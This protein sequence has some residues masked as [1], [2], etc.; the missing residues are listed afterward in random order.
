MFTLTIET[1]NAAMQTPADVGRA[2]EKVARQLAED[3]SGYPDG[4]IRDDN[5]NT[6][7]RYALE[8]GAKSGEALLED[9]RQALRDE[10]SG[11]GGVDE[12]EAALEAIAGRL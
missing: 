6:V 8:P 4:L 1:G 7:G 3:L 11:A 9:L 12:T 5:G 10:D 2:L